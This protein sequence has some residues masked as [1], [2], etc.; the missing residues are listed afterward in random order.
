MM[1]RGETIRA[2]VLRRLSDGIEA[3][4]VWQEAQKRFPFACLSWGYV[5]RIRRDW[6]DI[7][8][9][10]QRLDELHQH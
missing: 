9:A 5:L 3:K 2:F 10:R 8:I 1:A 7:G 4:A 6:I